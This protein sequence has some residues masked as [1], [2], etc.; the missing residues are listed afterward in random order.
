MVPG[1]SRN[2]KKVR[3]LFLFSPKLNKILQLPSKIFEELFI[4]LFFLVPIRKKW[5]QGGWTTTKDLLTTNIHIMR[6]NMSVCTEIQWFQL[7]PGLILIYF[8]DIHVLCTG[9]YLSKLNWGPKIIKKK[10]GPFFL[11]SPK[12]IKILQLPSK[13]SV[14]LFLFFFFQSQFE[15]MVPGGQE[16]VKK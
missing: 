3:T 14:N 8:S 12:P 11:F 16:I 4:F 10:W 9:L 2:C 5:S 1:G 7:R 13:I 6:W 15:N